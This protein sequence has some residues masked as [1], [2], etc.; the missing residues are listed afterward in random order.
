MSWCSVVRVAAVGLVI[1][2]TTLALGSERAAAQDEFGRVVAVADD[3]SVVV[4]KPGPSRG[5]AGVY[6]YRPDASG[7]WTE[8]A[9]IRIPGAAE[10][11]HS[12]SPSLALDGSRMLI[13]SGDP[14]AVVGAYAFTRSGRE[15]VPAGTLP[16]REGA[17]TAAADRAVDFAGILRILQPPSRVVALSGSVA[18]VSGP[19]GGPSGAPVVRLFRPDGGGWLADGELTRPDGNTDPGFGAALAA[20]TEVVYA[21][22][23]GHEGGVVYRYARDGGTWGAPTVLAPDSLPP[24]SQFGAA[25]A[26]HEERLLVGAPGMAGQ[27]GRAFLFDVAAP[28]QPPDSLLPGSDGAGQRFGASVALGIVNGGEPPLLVV[29]APGSGTTA[30][31]VYLTS[32]ADGERPEG[33]RIQPVLSDDPGTSLGMSVA[34][35]PDVLAAGAPQTD[36]SGAA[37]IHD[38]DEDTGLENRHVLRPTSDLVAHTG[39]EV[40]CDDG[41]AAAFSCEGVD[42][43]AFLPLSSLGGGPGESVSDVWGWTDPETGREYA[44]VGRTGG[45][46]IVD[47]TDGAA[48]VYVGVVAANPSGA[49]DLKVYRDHLFFT[50]DGAG[51]HG[52]LVFDLTHLREPGPFPKTFE[53]DAVYTG[54]ASAHN[55]VM[56]TESGFAYP[57][58]ASG[59]GETCGGG[60][61]AVDVRD[62]KNPTFAGCFTDTEGLIWQGRTHD[63]QCTVYRGPDEDFRDRQLCFASN[64]TALRI[65]DMTDKAAPTPIGTATYPGLAYVHQGWL[66]DD[67]R[68]Y[69][70][71]DELDELVGTTDRTR[72]YVFDV[73]EL[74]DPIL[75]GSVDGPNRSTD[76][77]LYVKGDRM[78]Q[79]NYQAGFRLFDISDPEAPEEIGWFDTTPYDGDPPGFVGAW[80]AYP[81][82]ESGT[83][84]V[85]SMNEG[86]FL[87]RP[88]RR[89]LIP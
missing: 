86:L 40:R 14:D 18:A 62:P 79:A 58:G 37:V 12:L 47:V 52:L 16:L 27:A 22:S 19:G 55:L 31:A 44:L 73:A 53:P 75:L 49:R 6:V 83:V 74:D 69:Y 63:A 13:A 36:G 64:E 89:E 34:V 82:L 71:N 67:H 57:V 35:G 45:A 29:G 84:L 25:L 28:G 76:H 33:A 1:L 50:G 17:P 51:N 10:A 26:L 32:L 78:Y 66:T 56:D 72:T 9:V 21:S 41:E 48:P 61:H 54:I 39:G 88:Q 70:L 77:N 80:T 3:G 43:M 68:Y 65:I 85:T 87:L 15:W 5:P 24:G 7:G 2:P 81:F 8:A 20:G 4:A 38:L 23:P 11:G 46:A 59:G 30:G 42:L 60:L